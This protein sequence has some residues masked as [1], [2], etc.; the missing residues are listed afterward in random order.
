MKKKLLP[1]LGIAFA[2]AVVST[3]I[4]YGL[5]VGKLR[6]ASSGGGGTV[7]V[8]SRDLERGSVLKASDVKLAAWAGPETPKG[9]LQSVEQ[10]A[11]QTVLEPIRQSEPV[12]RPRLASRESGGGLPLA[13]PAGMRAV[14]IRAADSPAMAAL[15]R[16]GHRVDV[17]VVGTPKGDR[18]GEPELRTILQ[19]VEVLAGPPEESGRGQPQPVV[20]LLVEPSQAETL[21]L[22]D[23]SARLRLVARNALDQEKPPLPGLDLPAVFGRGAGKRT[24]TN[25]RASV[26]SKPRATRV[27][28]AVEASEA[29][30]S[31]VQ[32][33]LH[34]RMAG[35]SAAVLEQWSAGLAGAGRSDRFRVG[36][37]RPGWDLGP[38]LRKWQAERHIEILGASRL[39]TVGS[40]EASVQTG[41]SW[42]ARLPTGASPGEASECGVRIQFLPSLGSKGKIHLRVQP[43]ITAPQAG[44][45][46][47]RRVAAELELR[48]GQSFWMSGLVEP[49][50]KA[51]LLERLFPGRF[52]EPGRD[53]VVLVTPRLTGTAQ[54]SQH[55]A[56]L[57]DDRR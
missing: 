43:E 1:L 29:A 48:D 33:Q 25:L 12:T 37:F 2:V 10:A 39:T 14:S 52:A 56:A 32:V 54:S 35:A 22:A 55:T 20:T 18:N 23:S 24:A 30:A 27:N 17:Q 46:T 21:G 38:A 19:N 7:L 47:T 5:V 11:G 4:F 51:P 34:L 16:A 6:N 26:E 57:L 42:S 13:I 31:D 40:R 49:E 50:E 15:L 8:A 3:G 36:A 44:G 45:V 53:L 9:A 41:A 28:L